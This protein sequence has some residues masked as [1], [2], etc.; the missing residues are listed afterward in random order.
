MNSAFELL[1]NEFDRKMN[2]KSCSVEG[3]KLPWGRALKSDG[4]Q[5]MTD[6]I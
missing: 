4:G 2:R 5:A 6:I 1:F 3:G